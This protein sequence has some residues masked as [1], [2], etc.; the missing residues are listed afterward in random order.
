MEITFLTSS[1]IE[2]NFIKIKRLYLIA[3]IETIGKL[4][5]NDL[6]IGGKI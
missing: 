5:R 1:E 2:F 6:K 4:Y 3:A